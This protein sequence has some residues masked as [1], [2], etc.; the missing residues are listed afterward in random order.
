MSDPITVDATFG[1]RYIPDFLTPQEAVNP[2]PRELGA[3]FYEFGAQLENGVFVPLIVRKAGGIKADLAR[4]KASAPPPA[5]P[6]ETPA[7]TP[8]TGD[9]PAPTV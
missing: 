9:T 5:P 4:A 1:V 8:D 7:A 2:T 6:A 3:G